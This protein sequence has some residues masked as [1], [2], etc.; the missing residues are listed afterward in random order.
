VFV[1][2]YT[3]HAARRRIAAQ[4]GPWERDDSTRPLR[5]ETRPAA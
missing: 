3:R 2:A 4:Q 1:Y 5:R